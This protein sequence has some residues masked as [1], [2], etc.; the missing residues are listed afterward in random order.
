MGRRLG[1]P[2]GGAPGGQLMVSQSDLVNAV[3]IFSGHASAST[4]GD[5][6]VGPLVLA[7]S[8]LCNRV[9]RSDR[10]FLWL[11][12]ISLSGIRVFVLDRAAS[13]RRALDSG[14][15]HVRFRPGDVQLLWA[16]QSGGAE[17][18][19]SQRASRFAI[20]PVE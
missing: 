20:G 10:L 16:D 3:S 18:G 9:R 12:R 19:L 17:H 11:G 1:E 4:E 5:Q 15:L 13:G 7:E 2:L 6:D 14:A 8:R